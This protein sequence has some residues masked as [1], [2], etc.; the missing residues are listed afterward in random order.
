MLPVLHTVVFRLIHEPGSLAE[1]EFL[2]SGRDTLTAI[3]GVIGFVINK[4]V[5]PKSDFHWQFSMTFADQAAYDEYN[6]HPAHVTFVRQRW[7]TEVDKFQEYDFQT[8]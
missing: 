5:S 2:D 3:P 6:T 4:Q 8:R 7:E 1:V